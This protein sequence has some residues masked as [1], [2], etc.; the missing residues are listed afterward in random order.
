[1]ARGFS[2]E[3]IVAAR[4][5]KEQVPPE[6]LRAFALL[7]VLLLVQ[8]LLFLLFLLLMHRGIGQGAL[9]RK[10]GFAAGTALRASSAGTIGVEIVPRSSYLAQDAQT[11]ELFLAVCGEMQNWH[12]KPLTF[13]SPVG[14][15]RTGRTVLCT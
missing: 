5:W 15:G 4:A 12:R 9:E 7:L 3:G 11:M 14:T 10:A 1:V 13:W 2:A 8:A 6:V